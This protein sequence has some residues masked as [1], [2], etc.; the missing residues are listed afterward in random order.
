MNMLSKQYLKEQYTH[1]ERLA[2]VINYLLANTER[3]SSIEHFNVVC[4]EG[5]EQLQFLIELN[6]GYKK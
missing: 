1:K 2:Y 6:N 3:K 4:Q 5:I